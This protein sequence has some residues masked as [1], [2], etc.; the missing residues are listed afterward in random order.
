MVRVGTTHS[1]H[2]AQMQDDQFYVSGTKLFPS[3]KPI[4]FS[5]TVVSDILICLRDVFTGKSFGQ[6]PVC[7]LLMSINQQRHGLKLR[8]LTPGPCSWRQG[9][10][11]TSEMASVV[12]E[13][14]G[15]GRPEWFLKGEHEVLVCQ[16]NCSWPIH[17]TVAMLL[18]DPCLVLIWGTCITNCMDY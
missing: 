17:K 12:R 15:T 5:S 16:V 6:C 7:S 1:L 13:G 3:P 11:D 9:H 14:Q 2:P 4:P 8:C 10:K 18:V